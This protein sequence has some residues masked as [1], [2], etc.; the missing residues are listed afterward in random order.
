MEEPGQYRVSGSIID[1]FSLIS[2]K[3]TRINFYDDQIET[4]KSFDPNDANII[5][6]KLIIQ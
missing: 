6:W 3:P 4:I 2:N 1:F 5:K